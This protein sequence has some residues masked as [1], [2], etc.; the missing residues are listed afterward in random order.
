MNLKT[1]SRENHKKGNRRG[2][3]LKTFLREVENCACMGTLWKVSVKERFE[4]QERGGY[5]HGSKIHGR[6]SAF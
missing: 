3:N 2:R 4:I 1:K 6:S 5:N